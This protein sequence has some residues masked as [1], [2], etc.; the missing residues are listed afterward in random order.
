MKLRNW[1]KR[2][3]EVAVFI[4]E[5]V[6]IFAAVVVF[7]AFVTHELLDFINFLF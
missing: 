5:V 4:I 2:C 3:V 7:V 6:S 1:L